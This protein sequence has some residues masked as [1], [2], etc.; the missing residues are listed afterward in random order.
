MLKIAVLVLLN[1]KNISMFH[2]SNAVS[3]AEL[4]VDYKDNLLALIG[5]LGSESSTAVT[6]LASTVYF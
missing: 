1:N 3:T 2:E 4:Q 6:G 5:V